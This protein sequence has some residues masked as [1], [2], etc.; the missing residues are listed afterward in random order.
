MGASSATP[1]TNDYDW[2]A[3]SA[4]W[5]HTQAPPQVLLQTT[6]A[7]TQKQVT[8]ISGETP[9]VRLRGLPVTCT[10]QD[11]LTF[12]AKY[13]VVDRISEAS[14]AVQIFRESQQAIV[15]MTSRND[16]HVAL[17][18]LNGKFMD[19][20]LI[21]VSHYTWS[22]SGVTEPQTACMSSLTAKKQGTP[23]LD[24]QQLHQPGQPLQQ[25]QHIPAP[26]GS[27]FAAFDGGTGGSGNVSLFGDATASCNHELL[28]AFT[29]QPWTSGPA[30]GGLRDSSS[31]VVALGQQCSHHRDSLMASAH[32]ALSLDGAGHCHTKMGLAEAELDNF[33]KISHELFQHHC[34]Q[35]RVA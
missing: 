10:E 32:I 14:H 15:Q 13:D 20:Y 31:G 28:Q 27:S 29:M 2:P 25:Q 12:F 16:A 19:G 33:Q 3:Q 5:A 30:P 35:L 17:R 24:R 22:E 4:F 23:F 6:A 18:M 21:D 9:G 11:V 26:N 1:N 8:Q 7:T 34:P